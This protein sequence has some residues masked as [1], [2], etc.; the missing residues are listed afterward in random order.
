MEGLVEVAAG[1]VGDGGV[2]EIHDHSPGGTEEFAFYLWL[3][4]YLDGLGKLLFAHHTTR[5]VESFAEA[6]IAVIALLQPYVQFLLAQVMVGRSWRLYY[7]HLVVNIFHNHAFA[8]SLK[9]LPNP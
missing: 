5:L 6:G 1:I 7:D 4:Y 8:R 9:S 2:G 3:R